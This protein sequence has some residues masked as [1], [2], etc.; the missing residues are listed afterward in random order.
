M[1][2]NLPLIK[3]DVTLYFDEENQQIDSIN[4][5]MKLLVPK[6]NK[7]DISYNDFYDLN[8]FNQQFP[9]FIDGLQSISL[10]VCTES[11]IDLIMNWLTTSREDG[12]TK[13]LD[14]VHFDSLAKKL[15]DRINKVSK[16]QWEI[17]LIAKQAPGSFLFVP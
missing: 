14:I 10:S 12:K 15:M 9:G 16:M 7:L 5:M 11:A 1:E 13:M 3:D 17:F 6:I 4:S 8:I 2:K